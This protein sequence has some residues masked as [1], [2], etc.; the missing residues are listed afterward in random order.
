MVYSNSRAHPKAKSRPQA[1]FQ[2]T[3]H[4]EM[5]EV[6][7]IYARRLSWRLGSN[8]RA[9]LDGEMKIAHYWIV[10]MLHALQSLESVKSA[11]FMSP[12]RKR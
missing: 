10:W 4:S 1:P 3:S 2:F 9:K 7:S 5:F 6:V 8:W 12:E 11:S